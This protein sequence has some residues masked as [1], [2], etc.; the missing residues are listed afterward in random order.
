MTESE[1]GNTLDSGLPLPA[2]LG[3][4]GVCKT[5]TSEVQPKEVCAKGRKL[6]CSCSLFLIDRN[7]VEFTSFYACLKTDGCSNTR[8][9]LSSDMIKEL[10]AH[11]RNRSSLGPKLNKERFKGI[12]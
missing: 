11:L 9:V 12:F 5:Q 4:S 10:S 3:S 2:G 7:F 6:S 1:L 8:T